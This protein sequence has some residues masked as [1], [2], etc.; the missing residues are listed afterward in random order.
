MCII[1]ALSQGG[2]AAVQQMLR[3]MAIAPITADAGGV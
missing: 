3:R 2:L 1:L